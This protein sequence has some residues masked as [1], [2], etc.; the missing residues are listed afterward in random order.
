[1]KRTLIAVGAS[2]AALTA[3]PA[4]LAQAKGEFGQQGQFILSA[5]RLM[6]F[7]AFS[8]ISV[9]NGTGGGQTK[10]TTT[11][12]QTSLGFFWGSTPGYGSLAGGPGAG[13][14]FATNLF[15]TVP[16]VG[17]D[18]VVVPNVTV[19]GDLVVY[20]TLGGSTTNEVD[21]QNGMTNTQKNDNPGVTLFGIAPRAGYILALNDMF[22]VWLRGG[23]SYYS[24]T[25]KQ[26]VTNGGN[27]QTNTASQSQ[28][29]I[30]LEPQLVFTPVP[31]LGFTA[32]LT[33]DIPFAGNWSFSNQNGG[34]TNSTSNSASVFYLGLVLGML[35]H[36]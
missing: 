1:M 32:G 11:S 2:L 34:Q 28:P 25:A 8:N 31:H 26:T 6:P 7:F 33:A 30:D 15:F 35:G 10:N 23:F 12:S 17:F 13:G 24:V 4:A 3:T 22:S 18:Y 14:L 21:F 9:D 16:R 19:G 20:F 29:A 27:S 36:F 5:D